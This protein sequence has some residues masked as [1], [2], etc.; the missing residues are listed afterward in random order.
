MALPHSCLILTHCVSSSIS[1]CLSLGAVEGCH[2]GVETAVE[3]VEAVASAVEM[4][5]LEARYCHCHL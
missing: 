4:A 5:G 2:L 1:R 3:Y